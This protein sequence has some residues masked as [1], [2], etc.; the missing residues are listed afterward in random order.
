METLRDRMQADRQREALAEA[1]KAKRKRNKQDKLIEQAYYATCAGKQIDILDIAK[2]FEVGRG[3]LDAGD[4]FDAL[5]A[6]VSFFVD[7]IKKN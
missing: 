7:S 1:R 3:G 4:D 6:R 2:V 5:C